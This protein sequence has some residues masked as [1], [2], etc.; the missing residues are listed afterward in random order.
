MRRNDTFSYIC[1]RCYCCA[2]GFNRL[3]LVVAA[4]AENNV[5]CFGGK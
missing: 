1:L 4:V 5:V 3:L 2:G